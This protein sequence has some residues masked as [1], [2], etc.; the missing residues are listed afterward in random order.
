MPFCKEDLNLGMKKKNK[1]LVAVGC[2]VAADVAV[3]VFLAAL[4]KYDKAWYPNTTFNGVDVSG[5]SYEESVEAIT[6][7]ISDY[8]LTI[9][10]RDG[11]GLVIKGEDIDLELANESEIAKVYN[12]EHDS[13]AIGKLTG[14][15]QY[16][17]DLDVNINQA[18][19]AQIV[20][21]S[22]MVTGSD[23]YPLREPVNARVEYSD[24]KKTVVVIP[25]QGGNIIDASA[26]MVK[27][28]DAVS[29]LEKEMDISE[30]TGEDSVYKQP[31]V[32][33]ES[34]SILKAYHNYNTTLYQWLSWDMGEGQYETITPD[35]I[36]KWIKLLPDGRVTLDKDGLSK[37]IEDFCLKYKT[38]GATR[39]FTTHD[40]K[41][42]QVSGGDYGWRIDYDKTL[43]AAYEQLTMEKEW[44]A[45]EQYINSPTSTSQDNLT[46]TWEPVFSNTAFKLDCSNINNDWDPKNYSE[47]DISEQKVYVYKDGKL[48]HECICVTGLPSDPERKTKLG[49]YYV[50]EKK[51]SY[52]LTGDDYSTPTKYWIRIMWSGTGYHYMNR[53][54]WSSW[55][56]D[57]YKRRGSHGCVNLQYDDAQALYG[58]INFYDAVFIHE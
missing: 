56:K 37:W 8:S 7:D 18:K 15:R 34:E 21:N 57:L 29:R 26:L 52:V 49:C 36:R 43:E 47:V 53:R 20:S 24:E 23:K 22:E 28:N 12:E 45:V 42:I 27:T 41:K 17:V 50:K 6:K 3:G 32:T 19:L 44:G 55:T 31:A 11:A 48:A 5:M 10:G 46:T 9:K 30:D 14:S 51:E 38:V 2:F 16:S 40:G 35:D 54:D 33:S 25:E 4:F 13:F 58:L 39:D 1:L